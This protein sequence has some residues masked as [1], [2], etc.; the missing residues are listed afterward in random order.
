MATKKASDE[1]VIIWLKS[2]LDTT[3]LTSQIKALELEVDK[4]TSIQG[5]ANIRRIAE[6]VKHDQ[7][8]QQII[9]KANMKRI[10]DA[11]TNNEKTLEITGKANLKRIAEAVKHN[12]QF[13]T[14]VGKAN[15]KRISDEVK[16]NNQLAETIGKANMKRIADRIRQQEQEEA[17]EAAHL[18]RL[19]ILRDKAARASGN[20][21]GLF[22]PTTRT[23][24]NIYGA[25]SDI[26][27]RTEYKADPRLV[28]ANTS[29]FYKSIEADSRATGTSLEREA[30]RAERAH[31]KAANEAHRAWSKTFMGAI[32]GGTTFGH[33]VATT[34]QYMAAGTGIAAAAAS[35]GVLTAAILES[36][37]ALQMFKGVLEASDAEA[38]AL[39]QSVFE[40]GKTYGGNVQE[41]NE[42]TL[43]L[44]RAGLKTSELAEG[45]RVVS[46]A[47]LISGDSLGNITEMLAAWHTVYPEESLTHLG[48]VMAKIA[49][50][51]LLSIGGLKTAT[52]YIT[53]A[54]AEAGVTADNLIALAGAW[55][56]T[57]KADSIVGT[58]VRRLF[59]QIEG[60]SEEARKAYWAMGID[61]RK[62]NEGLKSGDR[63]TQEAA[64]RSF[65]SQIQVYDK[66]SAAQ[67]KSVEK[68]L[69]TMQVLDKQ[70]I[71]SSVIASREYKKM[72]DAGDS[73]A[74]SLDKTAK[75]IAL[76][77]QTMWER[78]KVAGV[79]SATKLEEGFK[80]SFSAAAVTTE[81]FD[82]KVLI[83]STTF[84]A[85]AETTGTLVGEIGSP[86]VTA[87]GGAATALGT[88]VSLASSFGSYAKEA[89]SA[90]SGMT[91]GFSTLAIEIGVAAV[92]F[93]RFPMVTIVTEA[94]RLINMY[95]EI[96]DLQNQIRNDGIKAAA[97]T[98]SQKDIAM[99]AGYG[100]KAD[101]LKEAIRIE[102][103]LN[104][105]LGKLTSITDAQRSRTDANT[106]KK[107][108]NSI[109]I[110][111]NRL[112]T[113]RKL[114]ANLQSVE[115]KVKEKPTVDTKAI[116]VF[117]GDENTKGAERRNI[118]SINKNALDERLREIELAEQKWV[119]DNKITSELEIQ[120]HHINVTLRDQLKATENAGEY[121]NKT[122]DTLKKK[123]EIW[124]ATNALV[125]VEYQNRL[126][127]TRTLED[128]NA[129]LLTTGNISD[130]EKIRLDQTSRIT[131]IDRE[132]EDLK[133]AGVKTEQEIHDIITAKLEVTQA[134]T[135]E[136]E[137]QFKIQKDAYN[138]SVG[139]TSVELQTLQAATGAEQVRL[140]Q[141]KIERDL[142]AEILKIQEEN[143][144]LG[145]AGSAEE[146]KATDNARDRAQ[147]AKDH[148]SGAE[149]YNQL[150]I[151]SNIAYER[152]NTIA[153]GLMRVTEDGLSAL[154]DGLSGI[155]TSSID[156]SRALSD[157]KKQYNRDIA[158]AKDSEEAA[159]ITQEYNKQ[160]AAIKEQYSSKEQFKK[161]TREITD[162]VL[163]GLIQ[164]L[165]VNQMI[166]Q[167]RQL[168]GAA[169]SGIA[170]AFTGIADAFTGGGGSTMAGTGFI[171]GTGATGGM[172]AAKGGV[173]GSDGTKYLAKGGSYVNSIVTS[174]TYVAKGTIAGEAG[175]EAV[176]PLQRDS[177][178]RLGV[179][180]SGS[181][182]GV[183]SVQVNIKNESGETLA[184]TK[185]ESKTD[186]SNMVLDIWIDAVQRNKKGVRDMIR[187]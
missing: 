113:I 144:K 66:K 114:K 105:R 168:M 140:E 138:Y 33:K 148:V 118:E 16:A 94:V 99:V 58:E 163:K 56:Q 8:L 103:V 131:A 77:Y 137:R 57:G 25:Y 164:E 142:Q 5:K 84:N 141:M 187:R 152:N 110:L 46:Q 170:G 2:K 159:R 14:V 76:S 183:Q 176:I 71:Q 63:E 35:I 90:T 64:L 122:E 158:S 108:D 109:L 155:L 45:L 128:L 98:A 41:L 116:G 49:N 83:L 104:E 29:K 133:R 91:A 165:V 48:D 61:I 126:N 73:A 181:S 172:L 115:T 156:Q 36:D 179:N 59:K 3:S 143:F 6:Q 139:T 39:Q 132:R 174:P 74:G 38:R 43:T 24:N 102:S 167:I 161:L 175:A 20:A 146:K 92:A 79:E 154:S 87:I 78:V 75:T 111:T 125:E 81:E 7:Q 52:S 177:Q 32:E 184:V 30:L 121:K 147:Y 62:V 93:K 107:L 67:K 37:K 185:S 55:K 182:G 166:L 28:A 119:Y 51:S 95:S 134:L 69:S 150:L 169:S 89:I 15:I 27:T 120:K 97:S 44:G 180:A 178:G 72:E 106:K 68:I 42:T 101:K 80:R 65:M 151:E 21:T 54:G 123:I 153:K 117:V 86:L 129:Q 130:A 22:Q 162:Q 60:G 136:Q 127:T 88:L 12:E 9:G 157:L 50:E 186:M 145:Q 26:N 96:L 135:A 11:V 19:Y 10:A 31:T 47:A 53:A 124:K 82:K 4:V 112:E 173:F 1:E 34:F 17:T 18:K 70:T 160:T 40:V 23:G 171:D 13:A 100:D 85:L 149:T